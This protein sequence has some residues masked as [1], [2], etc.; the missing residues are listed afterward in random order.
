MNMYQGDSMALDSSSN[1]IYESK[2]KHDRRGYKIVKRIIDIVFSILAIILLLPVFLATAVAVKIDSKGPVLYKQTRV[3][4]NGRQ[5][6]LLKFRSMCQ[7]ADQKVH[8]LYHLNEKDGPVFKIAHDP[9]ITRVGRI[10][11]K[12]SI[13]ELPQ[14]LNVL[15]G[16][17]SVV[18]PRPPL[19]HEALQY[20]DYEARRLS[21]KPGLTCYWQISG[22]S[23]LSF[24]EWVE[25]DLKYINES[26]L[27]TD[28]KIIIKTIPAVLS[29]R[30]AY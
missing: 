24:K 8:E 6:K 12:L 25:L 10:I 28:I 29:C 19:V 21:I 30:G 5:F 3:C 11:R 9:R 26:S 27:L 1:Y 17:M 13:D 23:N 14:F 7:D 22:R 20:S 4:K 18:G 15:R 16:E 2:A